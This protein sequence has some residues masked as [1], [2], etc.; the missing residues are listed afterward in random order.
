MKQAVV[1]YFIDLSF[2][3]IAKKDL[4]KHL[5]SEKLEALKTA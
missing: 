4:Y 5:I 1:F 2:L 3:P